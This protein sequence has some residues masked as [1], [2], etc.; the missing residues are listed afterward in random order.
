MF[1]DRDG[2]ILP[3]RPP[4]VFIG[5]DNV[6][7]QGVVVQ[8]RPD[9]AN[10][11]GVLGFGV[12]RS[13]EEPTVQFVALFLGRHVFI[14]FNVVEDNPVWPPLQVLL[15][16]NLTTDADGLEFNVVG[17]DD[18][19]VCPLARVFRLERSEVIDQ[20]FVCFQ[21]VRQRSQ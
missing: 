13:A 18:C 2:L 4:F 7:Q 6:G 5:I 12:E 21:F 19:S 14:V 10:D 16:A 8:Y 3:L 11:A 17:R 20:Q 9:D 1:V 15:T